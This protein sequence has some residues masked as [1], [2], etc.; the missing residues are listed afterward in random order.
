MSTCQFD[1][2][3]TRQPTMK[4]ITN[5]KEYCNHLLLHPEADLSTK[6]HGTPVKSFSQTRDPHVTDS[7][8]RSG[9]AS[10]LITD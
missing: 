6:L 10:V 9:E 3:Q 8:S 5:L 7:E 2:R 1:V 4:K